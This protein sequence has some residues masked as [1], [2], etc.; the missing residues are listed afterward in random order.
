M[1]CIVHGGHK[2]SDTTERLSLFTFLPQRRVG[3]QMIG[4]DELKFLTSPFGATPNETS[5]ET[6]VW[7]VVCSHGIW[8][9]KPVAYEF[10]WTSWCSA[11]RTLCFRWREHGFNLWLHNQGPAC[12]MPT[13]PPAPSSVCKRRHVK[14]RPCSS[15][16][17]L[18]PDNQEQRG[19]SSSHLIVQKLIISTDYLL[20]IF[21]TNI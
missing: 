8:A 17:E 14:S 12:P 3:M 6:E 15:G 10:V 19:R 4:W 13:S 16:K 18:C 2:E 11:V 1:D 5:L 21:S 20:S 9:R 7:S